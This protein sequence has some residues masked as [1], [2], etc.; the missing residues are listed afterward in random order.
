MGEGD[1]GNSS[2]PMAA[3]PAADASRGPL[4]GLPLSASSQFNPGHAMYTSL[5]TLP[6][7]PYTL[8]AIATVAAVLT[9]ALLSGC[10][11]VGPSPGGPQPGREDPSE[12]GP[13][14]E[15]LRAR[16]QEARGTITSSARP[17][18]R[19]CTSTGCF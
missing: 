13:S 12:E 10:D 18:G 9:L 6:A 8:K 15:T 14:G 5:A 19:F 3:P 11:P 2:P 16:V 17:T 1:L 7:F 4:P